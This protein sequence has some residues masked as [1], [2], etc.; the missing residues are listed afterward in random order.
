MKKILSITLITLSLNAE[1]I[2]P[3]L[4]GDANGLINKDTSRSLNETTGI[5][6]KIKDENLQKVVT[7]YGN[8]MLDK[9]NREVFSVTS[10]LKT[11]KT[12]DGAYFT[13]EW[14]QKWYYLR[15]DSS[16][17]SA[18]LPLEFEEQYRKNGKWYTIY[19][20]EIEYVNSKKDYSTYSENNGKYD[21]GKLYLTIDANNNVLS[22]EIK[23]YKI[24]YSS[25]ND[26]EGKIIFDKISTKLKK[27]DK[28]ALYSKLFYL[29]TKELYWS[30]ENTE[31]ADKNGFLEITDEPK[32]EFDY[33][34]FITTDS[35]NKEIDLPYYY[36][37]FAEDIAGNW[38]IT[39]PKEV[40]SSK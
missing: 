22:N 15:F 16:K 2:P 21:Y 34:S 13:P 6:A 14:N 26:T 36:V 28:I 35:N 40:K 39:T 38:T 4:R 5:K 23:T 19:S 11:S 32:F 3:F 20:A 10:T 8:K 7:M 27:G 17:E 1:F 25:D 33:L 9:D 12:N 18:W 37:M 24:L 29:D 30:I 31:L